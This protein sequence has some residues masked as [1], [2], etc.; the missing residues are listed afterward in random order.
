MKEPQIEILRVHRFNTGRL[1]ADHGQII[2]AYIGLDRC[3][4]RDH[5]RECNYSFACDG[6]SLRW[7]TKAQIEEIVMFIYD[8]YLAAGLTLENPST[9]RRLEEENLKCLA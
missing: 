6:N 9:L 2:T 1:Y 5:T 4:I 7:K 8:H 3:Y